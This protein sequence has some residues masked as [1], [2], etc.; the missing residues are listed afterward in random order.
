[1]QALKE[2]FANAYITVFSRIF[3]EVVQQIV[4]LNTVNVNLF[5]G[6]P[7][8]RFFVSAQFIGKLIVDRI[9]KAYLLLLEYIG[10]NIRRNSYVA[11]TEV[12]GYDFQVNTAVQ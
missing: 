9:G 3:Y 4:Q 12:F 11:V 1:M 10:I 2:F 8:E 7:T 5:V 6:K